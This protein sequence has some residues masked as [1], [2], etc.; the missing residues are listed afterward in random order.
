MAV[1]LRR[2]SLGLSLLRAIEEKNRAIQDT[3]T[4]IHQKLWEATREDKKDE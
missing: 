4:I 2:Q 3:A 1:L